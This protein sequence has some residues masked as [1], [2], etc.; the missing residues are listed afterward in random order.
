VLLAWSGRG[1][2]G[3]EDGTV[4]CSN[5]CEKSCRGNDK[6][7]DKAMET[8]TTEIEETEKTEETAPASPISGGKKK[9]A[10]KASKKA[11]KPVKAAKKA[12]KTAKAAKAPKAVKKAAKAD[13]SFE[14]RAGTV[15]AKVLAAC[16]KGGTLAQITK[17]A[18]TSEANVRWYINDARNKKGISIVTSENKSGDTFYKS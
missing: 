7:K 6:E 1:A 8:E 14:P 13:G 2:D 5:A 18:D 4:Y 17:A 11:A 9:A 15:Y 3:L 12:A 10:K 16:A